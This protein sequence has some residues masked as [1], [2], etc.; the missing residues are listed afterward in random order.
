MGRKI[1]Q[2]INVAMPK[3]TILAT[4]NPQRVEK[5]QQQIPSHDANLRLLSERIHCLRRS[6]TAVDEYV[7]GVGSSCCYISNR[8]PFV[9]K[10]K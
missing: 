4:K 5:M 10:G 6:T 8:G 1:S 9:T 2:T 3:T 7:T